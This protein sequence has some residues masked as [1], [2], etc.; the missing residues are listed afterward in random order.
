MLSV[1]NKSLIATVVSS[2]LVAISFSSCGQSESEKAAMELN[3]AAEAMLDMNRPAEA[4]VLLDSLQRS[5]PKEKNAQRYGMWLRPRAIEQLTLI[6]MST[7]DSLLAVNKALYEQTQPLMKLVDNAELVEPYWVVNNGYKADF[8]NGD[9]VQPRVGKDGEFYMLSSAIG[10]NLKHNSFAIK[11]STGAEAGSGVVPFDNELNYRLDGTEVVTYGSEKCDTIGVIAEQLPEGST[12]IITL[13][14][15]NGKNRQ[16]KL[17]AA[18]T[19]AIATAHKFARSIT[20]SR[21]LAVRKDKLERVLQLSRDQQ[22]RTLPE[23]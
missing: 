8:L 17:N 15:E 10:G 4:I 3:G 6:E 21:N 13:K 19:S 16:V 9:G 22:A 1:V 18:E 11:T 12:A 2:A 23:E 7:V 14:G 5:Y 20:D